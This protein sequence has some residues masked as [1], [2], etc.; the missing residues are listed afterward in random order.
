MIREVNGEST[1]WF[2][3]EATAIPRRDVS[4]RFK[5]KAWDTD[6]TIHRVKELADTKTY[7]RLMVNIIYVIEHRGWLS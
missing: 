1:V 5:E 7:E 3:Q 6:Y 4:H 2:V